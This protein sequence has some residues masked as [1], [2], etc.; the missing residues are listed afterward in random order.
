MKRLAARCALAVALAAP[1]ARAQEPPVWVDVPPEDAFGRR[2][3]EELSALG[4]PVA[5]SRAP[6]PAR[7]TVR[8]DASEGRATAR[9]IVDG[10]EAAALTLDASTD[11]AR[12][13]AALRVVEAVRAALLPRPAPPPS[14]PR[15]APA[16][17]RSAWE[18]LHGALGAGLIASPGGVD[19]MPA[20][21]ARLAWEGVVWVELVGHIALG[22]AAVPGGTLRASNA[23]AGIG[24]AI[25]RG[26]RGALGV[27][28]RGGV[29]VAE[30]RGAVDVAGVVATGAGALLGRVQVWRRVGLAGELAVGT[31]LAPVRVR[32]GDQVVA[33]WARPFLHAA[34]G[35]SF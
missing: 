32:S 7:V 16:T 2:V 33:E 28:L 17:R 10:R 4:H 24:A 31:A 21:Y 9:V 27:T 35:V 13:I 5:R 19:V 18:D 1:A 12:A 3:A 22:G 6:S 34:M 23:A 25:L 26:R 14:A 29:A 30:A 15:P 8:L 20:L 11:A